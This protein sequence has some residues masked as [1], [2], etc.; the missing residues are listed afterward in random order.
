[1]GNFSYI[2]GIFT[3]KI[4]KVIPRFEN[5]TVP[6]IICLYVYEN[7]QVSNQNKN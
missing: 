7:V 4:L 1:M 6:A 2:F 3:S 5:T